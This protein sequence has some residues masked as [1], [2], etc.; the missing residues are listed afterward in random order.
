[1]DFDL[2]LSSPRWEILQIVAE[3]PSSPIEI[4]EKLGTTVSYISQQMKL[5]DAAGLVLKE[6]TGAVEKG[7]PR[8]L[9]SL[10]KELVYLSALTNEFSN[11]K[12]VHLTDHHKQII[13]IWLVKDSSL[14][15]YLEKLFLKL[16]EN[17]QE[18]EGIFLDIEEGKMFIISTDKKLEHKIKSFVARFDRKIGVEFVSKIQI[19]KII[20]ENIITLH[21]PAHLFNEMKGGLKNEN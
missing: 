5:L 7:K 12:L 19:K 2:F 9:F 8:S 15:Y 14:H 3:K 6:K 1:M 10:S 20:S 4:A 13:K 16:E 21:D 18:I 11:K 17:L